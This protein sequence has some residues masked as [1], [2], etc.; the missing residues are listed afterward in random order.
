M[1][2]IAA[3]I[4]V[5]GLT[6]GFAVAQDMD[7]DTDGY[8]FGTLSGYNEGLTEDQFN[9]Y[10]LNQDGFLQE[11]ETGTFEGDGYAL[12]DIAEPTD[13]FEN[14]IGVDD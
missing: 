12:D 2:T 7:E 14:E 11:N 9:T 8:D 13:G 5:V 4:A 3:T 10:D 1:K 6:T